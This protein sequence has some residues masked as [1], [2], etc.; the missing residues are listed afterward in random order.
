MIKIFNSFL[1]HSPTVDGGWSS[2]SKPSACSTTCEDGV[3]TYTRLCNQPQPQ[4]GGKECPGDDEKQE[5]CSNPN[6]L[7]PGMYVCFK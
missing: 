3:I 2:W 7:C 5:K 6:V 1:F 4:H